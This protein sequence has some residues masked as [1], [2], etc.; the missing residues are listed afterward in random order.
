[1]DYSNLGGM[2]SKARLA[3]GIGQQ[4]DLATRL[5]VSQQTVS[6]WEN[7]T[8]RPRASQIPDLAKVIKCDPA[9]LLEAAGYS[10]PS[11]AMPEATVDQAWPVD[12]L[13]PDSFERF[14]THF[15]EYLY[16]SEGAKVHGYGSQGHKQHGLDIE[17]IF[18]TH[19]FTFQCKRQASF[20]P[21]KIQEA[22]AAHTADAT[23]K[24][25]LLSSVA[26]PQARDAIKLYEDWDLWDKEDISRKIRLNLNKTDQRTLIDIFFPQRRLALLGELE[27]SPWRT[28]K[29][30][31]AG[32]DVL[33][34][35]FTHAWNMVGRESE[36]SSLT[37][38]IIESD[39]PVVQITGSGGSG[40]SRFLK[41]FFL[42][43]P[44]IL[45][46]NI[47]I[48]FLS[49]DRL[50]TKSLEEL[51]QGSKIL[52][53]DDAHDREDLAL[54]FEYIANPNNHARAVLAFRRYGQEQI[55]QQ[56]RSL[57]WSSFPQIVLTPLSLED[58]EKL[59]TQALE[60]YNGTVELA[61]QLAKYTRDCPLATVIGASVIANNPRH[62]DFLLSEEKFRSELMS[63]LAT[64]IVS[65]ISEGLNVESVRTTLAALALLQPIQENDE[66]LSHALMQL[67]GLKNYE[68]A[69]ITTRLYDAG[70]LFK[71]GNKSR[72][73]PDLLADFFI[74]DSCIK[75]NGQSTQFAEEVFVAVPAAYVENILLNL[76]KLDWRKSN[77]DTRNSVLL[78][79]IWNKLQWHEKY[80]YPHLRAAAAVAYYQPS[81]AL[82][83]AER[84]IAEGHKNEE[85]S[86][87]IINAGYH[88]SHITQ[89]CELLWEIGKDDERP[90]H[91]NP[92]HGIRA[93]VEFA[94]PMPGKPTDYIK[95][96]I[97]FAQGLM[98]ASQ[99]WNGPF[100]PLT[101]LKGALSTEGHTTTSTPFQMLMTPYFVSPQW[102]AELRKIVITTFIGL[103]NHADVKRAYEAADAL[104]SALRYP[105]G[106]FSTRCSEEDR[107]KWTEEFCDT[108]T[109]LNEFL[110]STPVLTA[111]LM[112]LAESVS[113]HANHN[114]GTPT[115]LA[116]QIV[117]R[118][119]TDLRSRTI[120]VLMDGWGHTLR[121][122]D[123]DD[124]LD[125]GE[126]ASDALIA[127]LILD[128]PNAHDLRIFIEECLSEIDSTGKT[129]NSSSSI[130]LN[131]LIWTSEDFAIEI[132]KSIELGTHSTLA[133]F[134]G[135]ALAKGLREKNPI[136]EEF[137]LNALSINDDV[138]LK[139]LAEAYSQYAPSE[140]SE[141]DVRV[142]KEIVKS[143]QDIVLRYAART[144]HQV[145][146]VDKALA[147]ELITSAN[148]AGAPHII[149]DYMMWICNDATVP[150]E[151]LSSN[152]IAQILNWLINLDDLD[153]YWIQEFL[154]KALKIHT[155]QILDF[156][157]LRVKNAVDENNWSIRPVPWGPYKNRNTSLDLLNHTD[158]RIWLEYM[159]N[160]ALEFP[161]ESTFL[162]RFGEVMDALFSPMNEDILSFLMLW[163]ETGTVQHLKTLLASL[164]EAPNDLIFKH[165]GFVS[166]VL[167]RAQFFGT[168]LFKEATSTL[169]GNAVGGMRS[170]VPGEPFPQDLALKESAQTVL[171]RLG[172]FDL[173]YKLYAD[174]LKH[175]E[176]SIARQRREGEIMRDEMDN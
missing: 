174:V 35:G 175:A 154:K 39:C 101:I 122:K 136:A 119:E 34:S 91:Q 70:V 15:L 123:L 141:T 162:F 71:R 6:R 74:E 13:S 25:I 4:S 56:A 79:D 53:C 10:L 2:I 158:W 120:R 163:S 44:H 131:K 1:M 169:Y 124:Y 97:E 166:R 112:R 47:G 103:L 155:Q 149:H 57:I 107:S 27:P 138:K 21:K 168:E 99:S 94:Q 140:Y 148:I 90:L 60:F 50:T 157:R 133:L 143:K 23:K 3:S 19:K 48:Y 113:W 144:T 86:R 72:I 80:Y 64:N 52:I 40:K 114:E 146:K 76:G 65:N 11:Q 85:V 62:P 171:S 153:D 55:Q 121:G 117:D 22:V 152:Q 28:A 59:A 159:L 18:S 109:K 135:S 137:V 36:Y 100:T 125:A 42:D 77:G 89:A 104:G 69:R 167:A 45:L 176:L 95:K 12:A 129:D 14:S 24:I 134:T 31:F 30:Y 67:A 145:S 20:G 96:V 164:K 49:K 118:L 139:Y 88:T 161:I 150:F 82:E 127:Q 26:S 5:S 147:V 41:S 102:M 165:E 78:K 17:A 126:K 54:L 81:Q 8:S 61:M 110:D 111:V 170:G 172:Q 63:R 51:G 116:Q 142:F 160:W 108:L 173:A 37:N 9:K 93:L 33:H 16:K 132:I 83:F 115:V 87:I 29:D 66:T 75:S 130:L 73:A 156:I 7:G 32:L 92:N 106:A 128:Y 43:Q 38:H 46:A 84:L 58:S 98:L 105:M 151:S 68:V